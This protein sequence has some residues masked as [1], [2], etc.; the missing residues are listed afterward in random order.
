MNHHRNFKR[1]PFCGKTWPTPDAFIGDL[2][3]TPIG[4]TVDFDDPYRSLFMFNHRCGTTLG[5]EAEHLRNHFPQLVGESLARTSNCRRHCMDVND[6]EL[7]DQPCRNETL[8]EF[9]QALR[10]ARTERESPDVLDPHF[11]HGEDHL[12]SRKNA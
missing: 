11:A 8:R 1:C 7:C 3:L 5:V 12:R 4:L 6:L 10:V 9:L 2:A